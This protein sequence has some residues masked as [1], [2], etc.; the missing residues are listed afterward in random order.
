LFDACV[1][2]S[3]TKELGASMLM[4]H[5][6][7]LRASSLEVLAMFAVALLTSDVATGQAPASQ[8]D[9]NVALVVD[10][11]VE[12][13]YRDG[14]QCLVQILVRSSEASH[15]G[16]VAGARY[17]APGECVY[18]HVDL[19]NAGFDR[20]IRRSDSKRLPDPQS[21]IRAF[22]TV[23]ANGRWQ[24]G[25]RDWFDENVGPDRSAGRDRWPLDRA[26]RD[27]D[28]GPETALLGVDTQRVVVGKGNGLKV[29]RV[30]PHSAGEKAGFEPGDILVAVDGS[31]L[32][33]QQQLEEAFRISVGKLTVTV[34]DIRTDREV[35]VEVDARG[36]AVLRPNG[37]AKP[38][39]IETEVA[40]YDGEAVLKV[41]LVD[42]DSP[43]QR[44]GIV[45]GLLILKAGGKPLAS[46]KALRE[47]ERQ[48]RGSLQLEVVDP[49]ERRERRVRVDL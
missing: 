14:D 22:L 11:V 2:F 9:P 1:V 7:R 27:R 20:V 10:G 45:P 4:L 33:S 3:S 36:G 13:V 42:P 6:A 19:Q 17:P 35:L 32:S 28:A 29:V 47:A 44:S 24:A 39:G 43:A 38:L 48:S 37:I 18:A 40:F 15:L 41:T 26:R 46:P 5:S 34:R 30:R 16:T 12:K 21:R 49:R 25:G 23:G 8:T 31:G